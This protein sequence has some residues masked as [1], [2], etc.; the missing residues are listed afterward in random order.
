MN[1]DSFFPFLLFDA[2]LIGTWRMKKKKKKEK[3]RRRKKRCFNPTQFNVSLPQLS[4]LES[5]LANFV[6]S[7]LRPKGWIQGCQVSIF[8]ARSSHFR[9]PLATKKVI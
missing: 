3:K 2:Q 8:V 6:K 5:V 9:R 7:D 4:T 1:N